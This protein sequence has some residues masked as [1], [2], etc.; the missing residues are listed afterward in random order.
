MQPRTRCHM[1]TW[2]RMWRRV[3][4]FCADVWAAQTAF[5][6]PSMLSI[7][8]QLWERLPHSLLLYRAATEFVCVNYSVCA[9]RR[10]A[11]HD[12][13]CVC[14]AA[15][16]TMTRVSFSLRG[17]RICAV[18]SIWRH[19]KNL[20]RAPK[21]C[22]PHASQARSAHKN[23]QTPD[24]ETTWRSQLPMHTQVP[25]HAGELF[26]ATRALRLHYAVR[27]QWSLS[28]ADEFFSIGLRITFL[29]FAWGRIIALLHERN[30]VVFFSSPLKIQRKK[31]I[32]A[33]S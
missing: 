3:L 24:P 33:V 4:L 9:R 15:D 29:L 19:F 14:G 17:P 11:N 1:H 22:E 6:F 7:F 2:L 21:H 5:C 23:T 31:R 25:H 8:G 18:G 20:W 30:F 16:K 28:N 13:L 32:L 12:T 26:P 10:G 27:L